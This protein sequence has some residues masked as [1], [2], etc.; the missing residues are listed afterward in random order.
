MSNVVVGGEFPQV[1]SCA[2]RASDAARV[3]GVSARRV[4][5]LAD[6]GALPCVRT[7]FGRLFAPEDVERLRRARERAREEAE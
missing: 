6:E 7:R 5:Q 1:L 2:L 4:T 3:L